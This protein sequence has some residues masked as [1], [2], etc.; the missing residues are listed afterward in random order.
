VLEA[1]GVALVLP[2]ERIPQCLEEVGMVFLFA[3][4][5]HLAMKHVMNARRSLKR[6]TVFNLLGPLTNPLEASVQLVGIYER[7]RTAMYAQALLEVG[8]RKAFVVVGHDG[9]DEIS[10]AGLTELSEADAGRV[11]TRDIGPEEFGLERAASKDFEGGDAAH[12]AQLLRTVFAGGRGAMRDLLLANASAAL[13][14]AG[15]TKT[16][17]E[18]V[19]VAAEAIDTGAAQRT[20]DALVAFT[21]KYRS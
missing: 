15:K 5:L 1:L 8:T 7:A 2:L 3:P 16:F 17:R 21:Q 9:V 19:A 20:L 6:K 4:H 12:N 11:S 10:T 13:V 14:V 18:G